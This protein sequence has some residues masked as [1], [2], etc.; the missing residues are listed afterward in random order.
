M[1]KKIHNPKKKYETK[2][3]QIFF[4]SLLLGNSIFL[5][6]S[7]FSFLFHWKNDQSQ[8]IYLFNKDIIAENLLGKIGAIL[9]HYFLHC[10]IGIC[11]FIFPIL[12]FMKGL[13]ILLK[14]K[15]QLTKYQSIIYKFLFIS[16]WIPITS[17]LFFPKNGILSGII[18]FE[19]ANFL[20]HLFGKIGLCILLIISIIPYIITIFRPNTPK[21]NGIKSQKF[22]LNFYKKTFFSTPS[23]YK[24]KINSIKKPPLLF[25]LKKEEKNDFY[26]SISEI[27]VE[28]NK[29]KI[30]DI[31][32]FYK[33]EIEKIKATIGPT[34]TLYQ[35]FPKVGVRISKIKNL[36]NEIALNLSALSIR[37]IAPIPGKG[38]IGIEIP[39]NKRT[40]VYM[41][42]ILLSEEDSIKKSNQM[43]LPISLGK[44]VCNETFVIDLVNMPHLLIAGATGQGKSVG[45][46]A[47]IVYL[48]YNKKPENMKF[49]FIDPKKVEL[50]IY[51]KI[52][53]SYF[54]I[55]PNS[56]NPIITDIHEVRDILNSLCK[57]MD[58][59]F[60]MFER[61][62]VRN[63]KEY[64]VKYEKKYH[65]PY[66]ILII[67]EFAD[68]TLN[69]K[70]IEVYIIRLAQLARAVG[71]HLII[72]TQRPSVD[73]ITGLIKSNF[74]A[75][76]SFKV[77]SKIDSRTILDSS[78]AEQLIGKGD[79]LFSHKNE[80]IRL[81]C[82][83]LN[84]SDIQN[85][86]NFYGKKRFQKNESF[87]LPKPDNSV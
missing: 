71:I 20:I 11:S 80:L 3:V 5:L 22:F 77:S 36:K 26:S 12:L 82:P 32:N 35:L 31:L 27:D 70:Y 39:N 19:I 56:I 79:L 48:L 69:K 66:I 68:L 25:F 51:N 63:I 28:N 61:A 44:T 17:F 78:G 18:G 14:E 55:L 47:I 73:V 41:K 50:S 52:S 33:I 75:R 24:K 42:T 37:I 53:K 45:L 58:K 34:I 43:E 62:K 76:I 4:G 83:F 29:K 46:N 2:I 8:L 60:S 81:Q 7:F 1:C 30:I 10:G 13:S 9:S 84:L 85:I 74:T 67:D 57:E 38:S 49:I 72:S 59:R 15:F 65:L 64:N 6:L 23:T 40:L 16:I 21:K 86:V 87:L 54:A